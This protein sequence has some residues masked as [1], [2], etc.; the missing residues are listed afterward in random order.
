MPR[1]PS[2]ASPPHPSLPCCSSVAWQLELNIG[3]H[4]PNFPSSSS[5]AFSV[6]LHYNL[7]PLPPPPA[8][9]FSFPLC[10]FP[11]E[12]TSGI[13]DEE[14]ENM[15]QTA[16]AA[17]VKGN[18]HNESLDDPVKEPAGTLGRCVRPVVARRVREAPSVHSFSSKHP[19]IQRAT[20]QLRP[21]RS[22]VFSC[23][24]SVSRLSKYLVL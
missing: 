13:S 5:K 6:F 11:M 16:Q 3:P 9:S 4:S 10:Q 20:P 17:V 14:M 19:L 23:D 12:G 18:F 2:V 24:S 15:P 7:P 8:F 1:S 22:L 21:P